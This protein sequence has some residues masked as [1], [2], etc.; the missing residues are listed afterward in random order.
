[1]IKHNVLQ[2]LIALDQLWHCLCGMFLGYVVYAD[3]TFSSYQ[4][5]RYLA[6][7]KGLK[8]ALDALFF[9]QKDHCKSAY[10]SERLTRHMPPELRKN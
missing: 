2:L 10:E 3:E 5:R 7:K 9:W 6:G 4:Y 1:M 8:Q